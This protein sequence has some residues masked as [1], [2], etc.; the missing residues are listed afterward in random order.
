MSHLIRSMI[1]LLLFLSTAVAKSENFNRAGYP[2]YSYQ[3]GTLTIPRVDTP[4][5]VGRFQDIVFRYD[6]QVNA[7]TLESFQSRNNINLEVD[8]QTIVP[9]VFSGRSTKPVQVFL[10]VLGETTCGRIG[11]INQRRT[12]NLFEV[13]ITKDPLQPDE[14][15][16][17]IARQFLRVIQLDVNRLPAGE[18]QVNVNNGGGFRS[19][20]L[21]FDTI[22]AD[23]C[24]GSLEINN[25]DCKRMFTGEVVEIRDADQGD[26]PTY[27]AEEG[28]LDLPRIDVPDQVGLYQNA[29][30]RFDAQQNNWMLETVQLK[31]FTAA[32]PRF[33]FAYPTVIQ[34]D[35]QIIPYVTV[36]ILG[37]YTCSGIG[38]INQR[39]TGNVFEIQ[40]THDSLQPGKACNPITQVFRRVV[41]LDVARLD[42][43]EYQFIINNKSF[44]NNNATFGAFG[45]F[46]PPFDTHHSFNEECGGSPEN[47]DDPCNITL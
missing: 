13:Q 39:R 5:Q 30:M 34:T 31:K 7:W 32:G 2:S 8:I 42:A 47:D 12:G 18:Y 23:E 40:V 20:T 9:A 17:Q 1:I 27:Y 35:S 19:F 29:I 25:A 10:H 36:H 11:Q 45:F 4:E 22:V 6:V 26:F 33:I 37:E 44:F 38:Q 15:C 3:K 16:D 28:L 14:T 24:G 43:G 21:P 41:Q 46:I